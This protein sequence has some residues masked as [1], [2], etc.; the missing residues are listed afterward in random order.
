MDSQ[1]LTKGEETRLVN[2]SNKQR[3]E[4][5]TPRE[6]MELE[7]LHARKTGALADPKVT[8]TEDED[9]EPNSELLQNRLLIEA[10]NSEKLGERTPRKRK[11]TPQ[12]VLAPMG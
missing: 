10:M 5:L 3:V 12:S 6:S 4:T 1:L 7:R 2:L 8:K 9:R 11:R